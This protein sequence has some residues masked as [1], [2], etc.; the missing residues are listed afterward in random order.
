LLEG[1]VE[2]EIE[3]AYSKLRA[4]LI[5]KDC[6]VLSEEP[7]KHVLIKQGSLRGVSP[8]NAKKTVSYHIFPNK[9]GTRI[10]AYSSVSSDW[11]NLTIWG[12]VAAGVVAVLF[13][14][15]AADITAFLVDGTSGYWTWLAPAFGYPNVQYAL[16]MTNVT[17]ALSIVLFIT[18][19]FE[20]LDFIVVHRKIDTFAVETLNELAQK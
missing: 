1:S 11:A 2:F 18:I 9:A 12:S 7:P 6:G 5:S 19:L 4:L 8:R 16:F 10:L 13:W 14:W 3:A 15:I 17:K 20:I